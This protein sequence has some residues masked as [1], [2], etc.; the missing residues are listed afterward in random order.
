[1]EF[2][3]KKGDF[4]RLGVTKGKTWINFC[5]EGRRQSDCKIILY[6]RA[7]GN[8]KAEI[9]VPEE[10]SK[11]NLRAIRIEGAEAVLCDYNFYIDGS[12]C[13]D[14]YATQ[15]AGREIWADTNRI[16]DQ[17]MP[18]C[19]CEEK[20]FSWRGDCEV[21]I[22][23]KD[24]VLYK[25]HIR[26]F[27]KAIPKETEDRGTFR[28]LTK[29]LSYL[30][31]LGITS[32]EL[33]PVYE[34]E[35]LIVSKEKEL[36]EY[37][38]WVEKKKD[39]I[40]KPKQ[41]DSYKINYWGYGE[42]C[43]FAPKASYAASDTPDIELKDCILQMHKKNIE[44]ILEMDFP[45]N[46]P[47]ERIID[48]LRYWVREYHVDGFHLQGNRIPMEI[49]ASDPYLGRT[50]FFYR[51]VSGEM[52]EKEDETYPRLFVDTD[53]FLYPARKL[54]SGIDG[55]VWELANQIKK[56]NI[57][58]GYINYISD[59]NGF[60]L[61][62]LFT[63]ENKHN[64]A[65]GEENSDGPEWNFSTNCGVEGDTTS[66]NVQKIRD[67]HMKNAIAVLFL[68]QGVPMLMSGDEDYNSQQ[69]NNNAYCQ[70]NEIGWKDWKKSKPA[71]D[72]L[73]YVRK[74]I[75][76]RKEHEI[77]RMEQPMQLADTLG[78]GYPDVSYHEEN[79][80]ISQNHMNRRALGI[81]Y[82]GQ[83]AKEKE[84][85]YIGF[86]FSNFPKNLAL[87][88][89]KGKRNWYLSMD[90]ADKNGFLPVCEKLTDPW[91]TMDAQSVC[92]IIGKA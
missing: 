22:P 78:C 29:K 10:F 31:S 86:N 80:W 67:R 44:C 34:F 73:Q 24:M 72:F 69:G 57:K 16:Q 8:K 11:G 13:L 17:K 32:I 59:N 70:D 79:A 76:F 51:Y 77:L 5:F 50:K 64:E 15:I 62:D 30:K 89:Q 85:V 28:G 9:D 55:N 26:G 7:D 66:R 54:L 65:N 19:R 84:D 87:P 82:C 68:A 91:Y 81:L 25:L 33:M 2:N 4:S 35:E 71:R 1:M 6:H 20:K 52:L 46:V 74:M 27:S 90:T 92:I 47:A 83:Y 3:L 53:E 36:P 12:I 39:K 21:E 75:T 63:Y 60:T 42:G 43:Y 56:Q 48:V 58:Y 14:P 23:R 18:R 61:A 38:R 45:D 41:K 49:I 40:K 88:K 37:T